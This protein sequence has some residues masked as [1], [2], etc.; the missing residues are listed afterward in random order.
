MLMCMFLFLLTVAKWIRPIGNVMLIIIAILKGLNNSSNRTNL[1]LTNMF[2]QIN[3]P[4]SNMV[5]KT[6]K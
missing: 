2:W 5:T 6:Y 1:I 3:L 4:S